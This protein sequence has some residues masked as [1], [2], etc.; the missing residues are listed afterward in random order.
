M[1]DIFSIE[2][3]Q[4]QTWSTEMISATEMPDLTRMII[5]EDEEALGAIKDKAKNCKR[6]SRM[7]TPYQ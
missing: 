3:A 1:K 6:E 2:L 5:E 7:P 4:Q